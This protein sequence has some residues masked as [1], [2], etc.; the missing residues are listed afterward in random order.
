M[1]CSH[2]LSVL[3]GRPEWGSAVHQLRAL[4]ARHGEEARCRAEGYARFYKGRRGS[5][6][7]DVVLS[8]QRRYHQRVLPLVERW[9]DDKFSL[10]DGGA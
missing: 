2:L 3:R 9:E 10:V 1:T 7:L 4:V 5:M 6:V 8:R